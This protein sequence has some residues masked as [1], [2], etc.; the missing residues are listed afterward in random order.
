MIMIMTLVKGFCSV[1]A[2]EPGA[3]LILALTYGRILLLMG[4]TRVRT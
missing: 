3:K 4:H 2:E 1:G